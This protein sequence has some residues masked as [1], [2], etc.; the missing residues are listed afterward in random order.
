MCQAKFGE[1]TLLESV[2]DQHGR[3]SKEAKG[4]EGIL[5]EGCAA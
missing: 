1:I 5:R 3:D 2:E 4:C